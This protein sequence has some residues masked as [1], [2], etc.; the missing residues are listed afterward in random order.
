MAKKQFLGEMLVSAGFID[1]KQAEECL[2]IQRA[3]GRR[4]GDIFIEKGYINSKDLMRVLENQH[5]VPYVDL[6]RVEINHSVAKSIPVEL[7][8]RNLLAPVK[9]ERGVLYIAMEDPKNFRALDEVRAVARMNAQPMLASG[10]SINAFIDKIYGSEYA[11]QALSE[12]QKESNLREVATAVS[13]A[14]DDDVVSAPVVRLINALF[15]QAVSMGASDIHIEPSAVTV[16]VRMRVDG[17]LSNVLETPVSAAPAM[18][19][20]VKILGNLNIAERRAPQDG[21]F[22][23]RVMNRDID[24]RM[25]TIPTIHGEKAVMR[26]LD[27]S[28]FFI[29]KEK[30]GFTEQNLAKFNDLLKTPHGIILITGPTGSG[31]STTLY[32]MLDE[33]NS[34]R[35]NITTI[36]D[37]VEYMLE[38][39]N[40]MQLNQRAGVTFA[41]GLRSILRQDPDVIMIGEIRDTETVEIAIRAAITGHLV[42]STI[43]TNDTVSTIY[44]LMDMGIPSYM[45]AASLVGLVAQRLVRVICPS[46]KQTYKPSRAELDLAGIDMKEA[47]QEYYRGF[48]CNACND[49]GYKGRM[50]VHEVLTVDSNFRDMVHNEISLNEIRAY[51]LSTGMVSLRDSAIALVNDGKTTLEELISITHGV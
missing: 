48:G 4:I 2:E 18:I 31:K 39:L 27:R 33:I 38:G 29:P 25:S 10:R 15:E 17:V 47:P 5:N 26:L 49:T 6:D 34:S 50:A 14:G 45:I 51:A 8:R 24:I 46:C 16:R 43:H 42:L 37:P 20:R 36:E 7:A 21:R 28:A 41:S 12:F 23:V 32:T 1:E 22:D 40:Q 19:A 11:R 9:V 13:E 30:L 35:D 44:R 3:T